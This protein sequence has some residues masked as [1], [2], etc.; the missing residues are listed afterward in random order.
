[1][2]LVDIKN[3]RTSFRTDAGIVQAVRGISIRIERGESVGVVGES[4]SGK[5]VS[6]LSLLRL[7]PPTAR[8][9]SEGIGFDGVQLESLTPKQM[10]EY[11]GRD[12]G[13][14]F[15]DPMTSL[16][17]LLTVGSQ[18]AES[19]R[20]HKKLSRQ[21]A[22]AKAL[23]I[24]KLVEIPAPE[25][26]LKQFPFELSGGMRQRVM[27]AIAVACGP[28][29]LV[30]DEPTTAL[31]VTIQAQI[32][33][34]M[35][36]LREKLGTAIVLISHDL[37][38]IAGMCSRVYVMYGGRI[39]ESG[40]VDEIFYEAGHPYTWGLLRSIPDVATGR[41]RKL[42]PIP[43]SPPDLIAPPR[44]CAFAPR[45]PKAMKG[46][47]TA[48]PPLTVLS[49]THSLS[50]WLTDPRAQAAGATGGSASGRRAVQ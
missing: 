29:L 44:G 43:G 24:L 39:V 9:E 16:N 12:I 4:G 26:R 23:E 19:L 11:Y 14:V 42:V 8:I 22:E 25:S 3:L 47:M 27:I 37:G 40:T 41:S 21:E 38:V 50:C 32:L 30:A 6:M 13:I 31:D 18:I 35:R 20:L 2:A 7:L 1:M 10:K 45:C 5:S 15:Q 49:P 33:D 34:L 48:E 46:C 17:P 36:G 28:K